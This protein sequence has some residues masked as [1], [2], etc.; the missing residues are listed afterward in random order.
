MHTIC[1]FGILRPTLYLVFSLLV[2]VAAVVTFD[3]AYYCRFSFSTWNIV[4]YNMFGGKDRGPQ[5]YGVE[6]WTFFYRNL[7][8]NFTVA[9]PI[10]LV[11]LWACLATKQGR[12]WAPKI[13]L[14]TSPFVLWFV[15]WM[16][17]P[18]KGEVHGSRVP[19]PCIADNR[20]CIWRRSKERTNKQPNNEKFVRGA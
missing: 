4:K 3:T 17:V 19:F 12:S 7:I 10:V 14:Y 8:L 16:T 5:L 2:L 15:F 1:R 9:F 20:C 18:H 6:P 11:G 13:W